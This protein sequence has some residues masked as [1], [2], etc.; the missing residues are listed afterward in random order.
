MKD[1]HEARASL[2]ASLSGEGHVDARLVASCQCSMKTVPRLSK[3]GVRGNRL[4]SVLSEEAPV[5][6]MI[7]FPDF[8][9]IQT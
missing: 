8:C 3:M 6:G 4:E 1:S 7:S 2:L 5:Q 9:C